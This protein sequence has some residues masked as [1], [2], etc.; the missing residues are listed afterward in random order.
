MMR[1]HSDMNLEWIKSQEPLA[2][3]F[4]AYCEASE[5]DESMIQHRDTLLLIM[6]GAWVHPDRVMRLAL[7]M[8]MVENER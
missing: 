5:D 8:R 2:V 6:R 3:W 7:H 4:K 1:F